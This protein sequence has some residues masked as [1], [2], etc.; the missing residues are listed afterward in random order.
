[1][2]LKIKS[3]NDWKISYDKES[4][5]MFF[6]VTP[7]PRGAQVFYC[8]GVNYAICGNDIVGIFIEYFKTQIQYAKR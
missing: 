4:D 3:L 2:N 7:Q 1:M 6:G 5:E 8:Q